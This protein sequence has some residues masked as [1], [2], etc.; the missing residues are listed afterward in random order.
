[1]RYAIVIERAEVNY[2][3]YVPDLQGCVAIGATVPELESQ[4]REAIVFHVEGLRE[5]GI[6]VPEPRSQVDYV[7]VAT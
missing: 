4:I 5:D 7:E 1:M 6:E 3:A 2:S